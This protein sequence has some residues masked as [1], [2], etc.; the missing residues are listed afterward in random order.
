MSS[1]KAKR[2]ANKVI[3]VRPLEKTAFRLF[4][5]KHH[6]QTGRELKEWE[7]MELILQQ[8]QPEL[9]K[10]AAELLEGNGNGDQNDQD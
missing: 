9:L 1:G 3:W 8:C 7:A 5:S 2:V 4:I 6:Q 10:E